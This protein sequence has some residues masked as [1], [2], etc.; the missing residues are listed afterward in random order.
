VLER[1][2]WQFMRIRGSAFYRDADAAL[3]RVFDRLKELG[4]EPRK[5]AA[6]AETEAANA[7]VGKT[8][9]EELEE[10]RD[11]STVPARVASPAVPKVAGRARKK[12]GGGSEV[13]KL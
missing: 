1:L 7:P 13:A 5:S 10:L 8:L 2:G 11:T 6:E 3:Q 4:I 12:S 9:I